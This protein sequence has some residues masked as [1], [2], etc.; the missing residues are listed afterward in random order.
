[1][2]VERY[3]DLKSNQNFLLV[4]SQLEGTESRIA[5]ERRDYIGA[6][7]DYDKEL[8]TFPG[9]WIASWLYPEAE[10]KPSFTATA[11]NADKVPQV[12][13]NSGS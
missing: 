5:V 6:V 3:P 12:N 10:L 13:F 11:E 9:K 2:V 8:I 7:R 1:M 4:Q